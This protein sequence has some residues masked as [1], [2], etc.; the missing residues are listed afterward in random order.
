MRAV[1]AAVHSAG[2][3]VLWDL[4]HSTGAVALALADDNADMA[5]GCSYKYLNGGPG[6]PAFMWVHPR[7]LDGLRQPLI[8]W[9]GHAAPFAFTRDYAAAAG[10]RRL[11]CG[12]PQILS[13]SALDEALKIWER[14]DRAALFAK[15][16]AMTA[17]F[18]EAVEALCARHALT[19]VVP[20]DS[21]RRG[22]HVSFDVA[23]GFEIMQ[24][25]IAR[26]VIGDFRAPATIRFGFAPLY[27][28]FAD[29]LAA[30]RHLADILDTR[31]WDRP[32]FRVRG[33]V[34]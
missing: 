9:M 21:A 34:T 16:R 7:H 12:T 6:A 1:T 25:L 29:A 26:G 17:F 28:S 20:R 15:G 23:N 4:S 5:V 11:V 22:S 27:L 32:E 14:V 2:A 13:L 18:I 33:S 31:S 8:G 3:V 19:L 24:A 10:A 30:A